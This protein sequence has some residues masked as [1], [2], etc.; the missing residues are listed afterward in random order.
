MRIPHALTTAGFIVLL[1]ASASAQD[2][3][4]FTG[5]WAIVSEKE[6][7][8]QPDQIVEQTATTLAIGHA[9]EGGRHRA[10]YKLDG[11]ENRNVISSHGGEIVTIAK[12]SWTGDKLTITSATT[13]PDGRKRDDKQVWSLDAGGRLVV[14][15]T[16]TTPQ[17][18]RT[19]KTVYTK[20][21][22]KKP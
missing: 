19:G 11:T 18:P 8:R 15:Y 21:Q 16:Q 3:P 1:A 12:A 5:T 13:Y 9:S 2:K 4:N 7:S 22:G 17:G 20:R 10:V 14:E 6:G